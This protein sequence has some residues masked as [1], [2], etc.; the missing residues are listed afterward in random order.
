MI[1]G[2][3]VDIAETK[4]FENLYSR[5]GERIAR[6]ILTES[7]QVEFGRR[8]N[9]ASYLATRFAAKEAAAKALGTGFGCG[10]GYKS[11]EIKNNNQGKPMLKFINSALELARQKQVENVFVSLS[12]E[13]HYVVAMV[14][15]ER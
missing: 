13:K 7:E 3:G 8:N 14:I 4:R 2:V 9:P 10:V 15:L 12:D 11:I 1:V 6:R 5:Y